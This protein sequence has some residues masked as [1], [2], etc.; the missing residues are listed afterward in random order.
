VL[1]ALLLGDQKRIPRDLA[2][3][4][5]RSGVN[6]ILSISGFH[7]GIIAAFITLISLWL[8][9]RCEYLA[10]RCNARRVVILLAVPAMCAYLLLTG[11]APAT[12][13]SVIM[14]A[15]FVGAVCRARKRSDQHASIGGISSCCIESADPF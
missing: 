12:A 6:H 13:R 8:I 2:D 4:Y 10:L 7:I 5:T 11:N 3:A 15:A 14:L 9:T 1:A